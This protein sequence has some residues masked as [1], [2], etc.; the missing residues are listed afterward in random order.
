VVTWAFWWSIVDL[1]LSLTRRGLGWSLGLCGG[2]PLNFLVCGEYLLNLWWLVV[3]VI[4][5][6]EFVVGFCWSVFV[7]L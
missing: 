4:V 7:D 2:L 5:L 6:V 3:D 1:S